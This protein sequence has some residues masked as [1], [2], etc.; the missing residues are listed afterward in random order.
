MI[1]SRKRQTSIQKSNWTK[2]YHHRKEMTRRRGKYR[3]TVQET[4]KRRLILN[5][6]NQKKIWKSEESRLVSKPYE[7]YKTREWRNQSWRWRSLDLSS[8]P[9]SPHGLAIHNNTATVRA[10]EF[11]ETSISINQQRGERPDIMTQ[12]GLP[13]SNPILLHLLNF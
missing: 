3:R 9:A 11:R 12:T 7:T 10:F 4:P 6:E 1:C 8:W 5:F 13:G 2:H